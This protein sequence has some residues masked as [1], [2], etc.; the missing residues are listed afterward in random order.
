MM[1]DD[2]SALEACS[3]VSPL[4]AKFQAH[5]DRGMHLARKSKG[6]AMNWVM[7]KSIPSGKPV[8]LN[9]EQAT[10]IDV[11]DKYTRVHFGVEKSVE[12]TETPDQ[13]LKTGR[14]NS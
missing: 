6:W 13:I 3:A 12:V 2:F 5:F 9:L 14:T 11:H 4:G 1:P 10:K 8:W 7:L